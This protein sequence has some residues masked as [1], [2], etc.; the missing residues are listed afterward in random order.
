MGLPGI[1][2]SLSNQDY[3]RELTIF[4]P[5]GIKEVIE[6][7]IDSFAININFPLKI[8]EIGETK[9]D[10]GPFYIESIY[11][12]HQVPVLAYSFKEK[13]KIKINKEKLAKYNIR[14]NPKL[15]KLKEGKSVTINGITLDPKEF[16][17]IQKGLK[18]T[19]ITD[20]LFREQFID[21]ARDSD[22]IFHELAFLDKDK[23]KAIEHY[24]STISDAFR[25]RDESNSKLLVFIHVSP[26]YQGSLFEIYQYLYNKKDWIIAE[27]LDYIEYKKGTIIYKRNDIV[28]YEYAIWRS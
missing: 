5:K 25:I 28:L 11:G 3:N 7:I 9:I 4:G 1:L 24:H 19:L 14:S 15:A 21:F 27:D 8:K 16:T 22:I 2:L 23:D 6:K 26:R 18:F 20:T 17:Y 12:I 13:D 10:F